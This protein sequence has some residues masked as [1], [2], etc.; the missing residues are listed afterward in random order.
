MQFNTFASRRLYVHFFR[1]LSLANT[2]IEICFLLNKIF[3]DRVSFIFGVSFTTC[4]LI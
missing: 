3:R 1:Q 4:V 2:N